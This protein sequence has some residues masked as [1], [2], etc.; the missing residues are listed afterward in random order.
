MIRR[1]TALVAA[2][3]LGFASLAPAALASDHLFDAATAPGAAERGFANPVAAN[4]SGM[5]GTASRPGTVPGEGNPGSGQDLGTPSV[6]LSLV[7]VRSGQ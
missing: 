6:D 7:P 1:V 2:A 5:S 4:P 3:L